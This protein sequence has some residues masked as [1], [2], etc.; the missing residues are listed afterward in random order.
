MRILLITGPGGSGR[1]T[2]AAATALRA[3]REGA[4]TLLLTCDDALPAGL[5][6]DGVPGLAVRRTDPAE[7]FRDVLA[8]LQGQ[9]GAA[10]DLL[11]ARP[12]ERDEITPLP[13]AR[14]LAVLAALREAARSGAH[15]LLVVDLPA[16]PEAL[17]LLALPGELRRY[18]RRLLPQERQAARALR[19]LLGRLAGV[20]MPSER[21]Y[22][23]AAR[24]EEQLAEVE[25]LLGRAEV[26]LTAEPGPSALE[27]VRAAVL[28]LA[29]HGLRPG[30]L[31]ATRV[32]PDAS[33]GTWLTTLAAQQR[34]ALDEWAA[35]GLPVRPV[36]HLGREPRGADDLAALGVPGAGVAAALPGV[37]AAGAAGSWAVERPVEDRTAEDGSLVWR[38]PL[39]GAVREELELVR[40]GDELL[41][42]AGRF[43][44]ALAL[45]PALR[46]CTVT[47]AA[48][49]EGV[50]A[51]RFVPDPAVW[52]R[53]SAER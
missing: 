35:A 5:V 9:A 4:R 23:S 12:L 2:V 13:G 20:P 52:P 18:L 34:K 30:A 37:C 31:L 33:P 38:I 21:L 43:R 22:D 3:A 46:R 17:A 24:W 29:L 11:G 50:L 10:F 40:R 7:G 47:G 27:A 1:T 6:P 28:G 51:V 32:V 49:R 25:D 14:E 41:L 26:R 19:P 42:A 48:L 36:P 44:R 45:P 8:A 53:P 39:P 15:D 16:A